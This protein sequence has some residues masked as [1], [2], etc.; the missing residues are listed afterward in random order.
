MAPVAPP[1]P[2]ALEVQH[3]GP[4]EEEAYVEHFREHGFV[5]VKSVLEEAE[6]EASI[7][8]VW[9]SPS[10]LGG[11]GPKEEDPS[12]WDAW[13]GGCRNFLDPI[14]PC[15]ETQTWKNRVNPRVN[16]VFDL[17]WECFPDDPGARSGSLVMSVDRL[18]LMR[19]TKLWRDGSWEER[20][21]WRTSRNWLHWDQN[22]WSTP[23]F[24]AMQGLLCLQGDCESSGGFVTVPGFQRRF[25]DW[26]QR[27]PEGSLAK[28]SST[29]IP[30]PVPLEDEIQAERCKILVPS[31][32]LLVW[33]SRLPHEN[34]P[35]CG[36]G[37]RMV[38]YVTCKRL[39]AEDLQRRAAA[40]HSGLRTG[41]VPS[42]FARRFKA[43][44]QQRLG[45]ASD[46]GA[47]LE[48]AIAAGEQLSSEQL[49]AARQLRRG[50]RLKQTAELPAELQEAAALFR[51][52]FASNGALRE[53]LGCVARAESNYLPF[54]LL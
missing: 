52:A 29:M 3:F 23:D 51:G 30:F 54:W 13:P 42:S 37:W 36:S 26:G 6:V 43:E 21:E 53:V 12:T 25:R 35:N 18:G 4:E 9:Q 8:E 1:E 19:P 14:D 41:L 5:V 16:R 38:Q 49:E 39:S 34:F 10:L 50:Y 47:A 17:L 48:A 24:E 20:P 45:M 15:A 33:D 28:R 2:R 7:R 31:G 44:E 32:A 11:Q 27:C 46:D 40:W 22:P